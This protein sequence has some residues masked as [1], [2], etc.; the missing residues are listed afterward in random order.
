MANTIAYHITTYRPRSKRFTSN[1]VDTR[2]VILRVA[3]QIDLNDFDRAPPSSE[4]PDKSYDVDSELPDGDKQKKTG[5][6][7]VSRSRKE[8]GKSGKAGKPKKEKEEKWYNELIDFKSKKS[9]LGQL[10]TD[11]VNRR[12]SVSIDTQVLQLIYHGLVHV[13]NSFDT[14]WLYKA[15]RK[16]K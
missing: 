4:E 16:G 13:S 5:K 7:K 6:H 2:G 11:N 14:R 10:L 15:R 1:R 9:E 3:P 8:S 12:G